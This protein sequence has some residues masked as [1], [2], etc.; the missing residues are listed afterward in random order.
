MQWVYYSPSEYGW[1][2]FF[3]QVPVVFI[4]QVIRLKWNEGRDQFFLIRSIDAVLGLRN[5]LDAS[6]L[7]HSVF[8]Q[9]FP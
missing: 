8:L 2:W 9:K 6:F 4:Y 3:L 5:V 7:P 1:W